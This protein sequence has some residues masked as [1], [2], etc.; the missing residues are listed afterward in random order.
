MSRGPRRRGRAAGAPIG[1][2]LTS[3]IVDYVKQ[4]GGGTV[5]VASQSSAASSI[6]SGDVQ[7]AGIGG[8]SGRESDV[9]VSW[10]AQE[11]RR[12]DPLGARR[13]RAGAASGAGGLAAAAADCGRLPGDTRTGARPRCGGREGLSRGHAA[14]FGLYDEC[15]AGTAGGASGGA[16]APARSMTAR[17]RRGPAEPRPTA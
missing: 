15:A 6:I 1:G 5:A 11:V 7:A 10:L 8:F 4:H 16:A 17:A 3:A 12:A 9:S 14:R 2:S 13:I